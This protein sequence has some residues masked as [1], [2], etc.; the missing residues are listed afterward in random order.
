MAILYRSVVTSCG[1]PSEMH[2][3]ASPQMLRLGLS[4]IWHTSGPPSELCRCRVAMFVRP[5]TNWFLQ[6][7][8]SSREIFLKRRSECCSGK[9]LPLCCKGICAL[10]SIYI[11]GFQGSQMIHERGENSAEQVILFPERWRS[12]RILFVFRA[13]E[14]WIIQIDLLAHK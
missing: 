7:S 1:T 12:F 9:P 2:N 5:R 4:Q 3:K 8:R 6:E 10:R 13:V 11:Y 14:P